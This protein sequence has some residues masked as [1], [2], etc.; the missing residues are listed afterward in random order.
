MSSYLE[1]T[2]GAT[3][4]NLDQ[5]R[6]FEDLKKPVPPSNPSLNE[7]QLIFIENYSSGPNKFHIGKS[8]E[9]AGVVRQSYQFWMATNPI[10]NA[11]VTDLRE[12]IVDVAETGLYKSAAS[13]EPW[14]IKFILERLGKKRG[15]G[16][17]FD[18]TSGNQP[19]QINIVP[20]KPELPPD[21]SDSPSN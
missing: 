17:N 6:L 7:K 20:A 9:A 16:L 11:I 3:G 12:N 21:V 8:C 5:Y 15:Y 18:I 10:F 1:N 14:A 19:L 2:T 13:G 4:E